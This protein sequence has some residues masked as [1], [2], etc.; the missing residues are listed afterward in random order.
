MRRVLGAA[1][2]VVAGVWVMSGCS[3]LLP[4]Q[5]MTETK[6]LDQSVTSIKLDGRSGGVTVHGQAGLAKITVQRK[7]TYHDTTPKQDTYRVDGG[8]LVLS[9]DCGT[10]CSVDYDVTAPAG[11]PVSGKT[12]NGGVEL[13]NVGAVD[14]T[15]S[16]G[17]IDLAD[18]AGTVKAETSNGEITGRGLRG[19]NVQAKTSNG[20]IDLALLEPGDVTARTDNGDI[21]LAVPAGGYRVTTQN[22]NGH[23]K[24]GVTEDPNGKNT[25]DLG[26]DNG[27]IEV[28]QA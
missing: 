17:E 27:D 12:D 9:G 26:S 14:V 23:R 5:S 13:R 16:S 19:G 18:V 20:R 11:L 22:H 7:I 28:A 15:T 21:K 10:N 2:L 4:P 6:T 24:I 25:L 3:H 1:G 8:V